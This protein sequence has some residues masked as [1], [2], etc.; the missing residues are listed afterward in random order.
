MWETKVGLNSALQ[1][2]SERTQIPDGAP[3]ISHKPTTVCFIGC[4]SNTSA[5]QKPRCNCRG[6]RIASKYTVLSLSRA[7]P[8]F[9]GLPQKPFEKIHTV[10]TKREE[11]K[12]RGGSHWCKNKKQNNKLPFPC[13]LHIYDEQKTKTKNLLHVYKVRV[14]TVELEDDA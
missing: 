5:R 9:C 2:L 10:Q 4:F 12:K 6:W 7:D 1:G 3:A 11:V 13:R 8:Y 14:H